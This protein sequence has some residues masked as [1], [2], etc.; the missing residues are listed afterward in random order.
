[1]VAGALAVLMLAAVS[2]LLTLVLAYL[3]IYGFTRWG[4]DGYTHTVGQIFSPEV[5]LIFVLK[6]VFLSLAVSLIPVASVLYDSSRT[7]SRTSVELRGLVRMFL[8]I[9]LIEVAS[10]VGNYY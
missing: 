7:R 6:I 1:V 2:S 8:V 5:A 9:L 10:L 3:S 4:F